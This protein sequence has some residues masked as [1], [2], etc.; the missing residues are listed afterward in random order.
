[1]QQKVRFAVQLLGVFMVISLLFFGV[2]SFNLVLVLAALLASFLIGRLFCGWFCPLG[3]FMEHVVS[4]FSRKGEVPAVVRHKAFRLIFFL[5]FALFLAWAVISL[6]RLWASMLLVA[7]MFVLGS[8]FGLLYAPKTW[9]AHVC[10]WGS[11]MSVT[12]RQ[13]LFSHRLEG[14]RKCYRCTSAC[15]KPEMLKGA[16]QAAENSGK[17]PKLADCIGC[18]RCTECCPQQALKIA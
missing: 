2:Y 7:A 17:L 3:A 16:L 14:C 6:P 10:P 18:Q 4:R 11:L 8:A 9:C 5:G 15:F 1:V 12:G 13:L